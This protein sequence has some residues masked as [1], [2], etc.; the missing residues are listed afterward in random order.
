MFYR[1]R[2]MSILLIAAGLPF[3]DFLKSIKYV[4]GPLSLL[5]FLA[6][7][8][9]AIYW[10]SVNDKKGLHYVYSLFKDK[11]SEDK[12]YKLAKT[13]I[14]GGF[15][16]MAFIFLVSIAGWLIGKKIDSNN[17]HANPVHDV[18]PRKK[19]LAEA[20]VATLAAFEKLRNHPFNRNVGDLKRKCDLHAAQ[21]VRLYLNVVKDNHDPHP[22]WDVK[23]WS[24]VSA[25]ENEARIA[26]G[27][28][29]GCLD[30]Y[31][32]YIE[33]LREIESGLKAIREASD[34]PDGKTSLNDNAVT[35][36]SK[37]RRTYELVELV[38]R[39]PVIGDY[40]SKIQEFQDNEVWNPPGAFGDAFVYVNGL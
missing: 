21:T 39:N 23:D 12:F 20:K 38:V 2:P 24:K 26:V 27:S 9:L 19:T 4:T 40:K 16:F 14:I 25:K 7:V 1:N 5:A 31:R 15:F 10:R 22:D 3:G 37:I 13:I 11:L 32:S 8:L 17:G 33:I 18:P 6:V 35:N 28:L 29:A 30:A 34:F 36:I